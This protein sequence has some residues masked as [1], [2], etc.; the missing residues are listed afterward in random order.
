M[1]PSSLSTFATS[2]LIFECGISTLSL[3]AVE[4]LRRRVTMSPRGS[5]TGILDCSL[6]PERH[7][8]TLEQRQPALVGASG[9]HE[10]DVEPLHLL[11][12]VV[13][14]LGEDDLLAHAEGVVA[15]AVERLA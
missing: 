4:P 12:L 8:K 2:S 11:D 3:R 10:G 9:S 15:A 7:S 5:L 6:L 1:K 13:V 14:D